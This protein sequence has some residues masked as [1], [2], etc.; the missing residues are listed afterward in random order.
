M[1]RPVTFDLTGRVETGA[2][3]LICFR[4]PLAG[5]TPPAAATNLIQRLGNALAAIAPE[6][7]ADDGEG[8]GVMSPT[9]PLATLRRKAT[10]SWGWDFGPRLPSIGPWRPIELVQEWVLC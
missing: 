10:F 3:L 7:P 9:L 1:F 5:L 8:V 2:D 6:E 4:P